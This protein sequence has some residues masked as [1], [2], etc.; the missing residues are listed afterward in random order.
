MDA[1]E[2]GGA[3]LAPGYYPP[4]PS[5]S[6]AAASVR[7]RDGRG[8]GVGG[9]PRGSLSSGGGDGGGGGGGGGGIGALTLFTKKKNKR[10]DGMDDIR[11]KKSH[12]D[13][14]FEGLSALSHTDRR[15]VETTSGG[16]RRR[17]VAVIGEFH[18]LRV[19]I[20][21]DYKN[22]VARRF[23]AV[24]GRGPRVIIHATTSSKSR[25]DPSFSLFQT[26]LNFGTTAPACEHQHVHTSVLSFSRA[27]VGEYINKREE[28]KKKKQNKTKQNK[29]RMQLRRPLAPDGKPTTRLSSGWR[30][31]ERARTC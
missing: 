14:W 5:P 8:D 29:R 7:E 10:K 9:G 6:D 12:K 2:K 31:R 1:V 3:A 21:E 20:R 27:F 15:V 26:G 19:R 30:T 17:F 16:L 25:L 23:Y 11:G 22:T 13:V 18:A 28:V 24:T 4:E